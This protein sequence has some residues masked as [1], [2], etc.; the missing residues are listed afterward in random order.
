[1]KDASSY[2]GDDPYVPWDELIPPPSP[3]DPH[4]GNQ[5]VPPL[6][7]GG[8]ELILSVEVWPTHVGFAT[9]EP[10]SGPQP[11]AEPVFNLD[12]QRGQIG[13]TTMP[14]GEVVGATRVMVPPGMYTHMLYLHGPGDLPMMCGSRRLPHP[15]VFREAGFI[16]VDPICYGDWAISKEE[17][18]A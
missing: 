11:A 13:W 14:G 18:N 9:D 8:G 2:W 1:M 12:Y 16:D 17:S 10:G 4:R 15:V 6:A 5:S 7:G 3:D